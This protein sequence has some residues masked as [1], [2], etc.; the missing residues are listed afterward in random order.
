[1]TR[2]QRE[3]GRVMIKIGVALAVMALLCALYMGL[4]VLHHQH[5]YGQALDHSDHEAIVRGLE[6]QITLLKAV[7]G[8]IVTCL[9]G[10]IALLFRLLQRQ[11]SML[12]SEV[13]HYASAKLELIQSNI[14]TSEVMERLT[15][16]LDR[17]EKKIK[18]EAQK[19]HV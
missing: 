4:L 7:G 8:S 5:V 10:T 18:P 6:G 17:M 19:E 13:K 15:Q 9:M 1:M 2:D 12:I 14:K 16:A 11:H 3:G